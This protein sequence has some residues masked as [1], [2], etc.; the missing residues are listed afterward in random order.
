MPIFVS[1]K[2]N[3]RLGW[4]RKHEACM[5]PSLDKANYISFSSP[6]VS[7]TTAAKYLQILVRPFRNMQLVAIEIISTHMQSGQSIKQQGT[8]KM[9]FNTRFSTVFPSTNCILQIQG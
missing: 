4:K 2:N 6:S 9:K 8:S 3:E 1:D 7:S 5:E